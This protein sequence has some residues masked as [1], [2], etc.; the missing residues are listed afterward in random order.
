M[1]RCYYFYTPFVLPVAGAFVHASVLDELSGLVKSVFVKS[2]AGDTVAVV[3]VVPVRARIITLLRRRWPCRPNAPRMKWRSNSMTALNPTG[4][5]RFTTTN[6]S[7]KR[8]LPLPMTA[9]QP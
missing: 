4:I 5:R 8:L 9:K 6:C 2:V 7:G 3:F 1:L